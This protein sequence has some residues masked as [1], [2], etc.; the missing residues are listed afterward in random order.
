M[1][2]FD[3]DGWTAVKSI[4]QLKIEKSTCLICKRLCLDSC[5]ECTQCINCIH[6]ECK[7]LQE[8]SNQHDT[9]IWLCV[10][11]SD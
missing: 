1:P 10:R 7:G 5:I 8:E 4:Y 9:A 6:Y 11:C 2:Y 3:D